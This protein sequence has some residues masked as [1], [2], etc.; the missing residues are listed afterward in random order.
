M[1]FVQF[2]SLA[3]AAEGAEGAEGLS[4]QGSASFLPE[5]HHRG[6][7][8]GELPHVNLTLLK[9]LHQRIEL[10]LHFSWDPAKAMLVGVSGVR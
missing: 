9:Q 5:G 3:I 4:A 7:D 6:G 2:P 8:D 10:S 1:K